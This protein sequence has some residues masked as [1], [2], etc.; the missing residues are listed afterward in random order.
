MNPT[1][2]QVIIFA[3]GYGTRLFPITKT[4]PKPLLNINGEAVIVRLIEKLQIAGYDDVIINVSYLF[5]KITSCLGDGS[6]YG[7]KIKYSYEIPQPLETVGAIK[8]ALQNKLLKYD[9]PII[10]ISSDILTSYPFHKL[11]N[12]NFHNG[13]LVLVPNPKHN[14]KG[15]FSCYNGILGD[16][17]DKY[18]YSGIGI[19]QPQYILENG[20][21][22]KI[23]I[24][25]KSSLKNCLL[26]AEVFK[27]QWKDIGI[28]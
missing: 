15:D 20:V 3:A 26:T 6:K 21:S 5:D 4:I 25:I 13:H 10:T 23:G 14:P 7:I 17:K 18:T 28:Q 2:P 1:K 12:L 9:R 24:V 16:N 27:G 19:F 8:F 22:D 11:T